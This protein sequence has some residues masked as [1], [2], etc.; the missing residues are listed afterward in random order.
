VITRFWLGTRRSGL[1]RAAFS[2]HWYRIHGPYGLA[3]PG[4][5]AYVQ[6]HLLDDVAGV[7]APTFDGCS[8]LDF[9][10]VPAMQ[11]AF[12][13]LEMEEADRDERAFADPDRFSI[14]VAE[15]RV[16]FGAEVPDSDARL[17]CFVRANPRCSRSELVETV[18]G[19]IADQAERANAV[20]AELL[21]A[22]DEAPA[23]Q[24][25]DL[26]VSLWFAAQPTM[27]E[28]APGWST[29]SSEALAGYASGRETVL[30]RPRRL[31]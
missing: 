10:D 13:S 1:S 29:A 11:A 28:A 7:P 3:L 31:R 4:L 19:V 27:L 23:P 18:E 22:V 2:E 17:L 24:A 14:V 6:N 15:R 21:V 20:R 9:D 8:E 12:T 5:R 26:V 30:V 25:C 16:L